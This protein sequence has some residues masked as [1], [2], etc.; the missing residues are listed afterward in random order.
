[1]I[2]IIFIK[3][4]VLIPWSF[5]ILIKVRIFKLDEFLYKDV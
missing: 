1:M 4:K 5:R 2:H 3:N